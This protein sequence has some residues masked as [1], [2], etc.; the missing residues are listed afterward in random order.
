MKRWTILVFMAADNDL[1]RFAVKDLHEMES[2]GSND[3]FDLVVQVDRYGNGERG[4]ALRGRIVKDQNWAPFDFRFVSPLVSIGETN[5]GDP[6]VLQEFV[7]WGVINHPAERYALIIWNHGSGWK[8]EFIYEQAEEVAGERLARAMR[9]V[10]FAE[11]YQK[12]LTRILFRENARG[13]V[14]GFIRKTLVPLISE[15]ERRFLVGE[16]ALMMS[17]QHSPSDL[18][19]PLMGAGDR[20]ELDRE[21]EMLVDRAIGLD[22]TSQHDALDSIELKKALDSAIASIEQATG[23]PFKFEILGFD[24][25]LMAGLEVAFQVR[26]VAS[27]VVASEEIEPAI[28]W[29]YDFLTKL[30]ETADGNIDGRELA[31]GMVT[32]YLDG[33]QDYRI[34]LVTQS[35]FDMT[36]VEDVALKLEALGVLVDEM[37]NPEYRLLAKSEKNATRF[38]DTDFLDLGHFASILKE[39]KN[40]QRIIDLLQSLESFILRSGFL[41]GND[42]QKP[43]GL[44]IYFPTKPLYDEAYSV[45]DLTSHVGGWSTAIKRYHFLE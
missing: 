4:A 15:P 38:Y 9:N 27:F 3:Q 33:M 20:N 6:A 43:T 40:D 26:N 28:G 8:P 18:P 41:F 37:I 42:R 2:V 7:E 19:V 32:S 23:A 24:A 14:T 12:R 31:S 39:L 17:I 45:L 36:A 21:L 1:D 16:E 29:R 30:I 10:D 35:A 22:E 25:C 11:R 34:R 13:V 5:T 44:S